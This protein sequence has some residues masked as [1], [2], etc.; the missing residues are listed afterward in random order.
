VQ[1]ERLPCPLDRII[2]IG[3]GGDRALAR[4]APTSPPAAGLRAATRDDRH[5]NFTIE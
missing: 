4:P 5:R 3:C 2:E 1:G